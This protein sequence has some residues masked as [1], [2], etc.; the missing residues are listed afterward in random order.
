MKG[1]CRFILA[2]EPEPGGKPIAQQI[3]L[4]L[5]SIFAF[6]VFGRFSARGDNRHYK[7]KNKASN[8]FDPCRCPKGL[9]SSVFGQRSLSALVGSMCLCRGAKKKPERPRTCAEP[10]QKAPTHLVLFSDLFLLFFIF[11]RFS[12]AVEFKNTKG[13]GKKSMSKMFYKTNEKYSI[14][15]CRFFFCIC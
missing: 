15:P 10:I 13:L 3:F 2:E 11:R 5:V 9:L 8:F 4:D 1:S 6:R 12:A 7:S 14:F